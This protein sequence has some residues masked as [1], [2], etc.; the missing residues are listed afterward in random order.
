MSKPYKA[1]FQGRERCRMRSS[2]V[3]CVSLNH[4]H[5]GQQRFVTEWYV[6]IRN[7]RKYSLSQKFQDYRLQKNQLIT[8]LE[9]SCIGQWFYV[10]Q[11]S[12]SQMKECLPQIIGLCLETALVVLIWGWGASGTQWAD[13]RDVAKHIMHKSAPRKSTYPAQ[14]ASHAKVEKPWSKIRPKVSLESNSSQRQKVETNIFQF[15]RL[16]YGVAKMSQSDETFNSE[17]IIQT[18]TGELSPTILCQLGLGQMTS[19]N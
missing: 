6:L 11:D 14:N 18:V 5:H 10:R 12:G 3:K 8:A 15:P 9:V 7:F 16:L 13:S 17:A 1:N 4:R 2:L 19:Y